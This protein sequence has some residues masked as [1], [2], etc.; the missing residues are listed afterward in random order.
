MAGALIIDPGEEPETILGELEGRG[1]D[2]L[3]VLVT[4]GHFDHVGAVAAIARR[5]GVRVYMS[6]DESFLLERINDYLFPGVGPFEAYSPDRLLAGGETLEIG[7]FGIEV[8][9]V[10]GHSPGH[11]AYLIDGAL[12]SGD[13]LF[14]GSVGRTDLPGGDWNTL[15]ATIRG[16]A[17][18]FPPETPV[19]SGH[20]PETTLGA[21]LATNPFLAGIG[22]P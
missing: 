13:V 22:R 10:P 6:A 14:A 20:G 17:E 21:E 9:K 2:P 7:P 19:L 11:L 12:F 16:L 1:L 4:H 8:L 18:R 3:A 15:E 5:A